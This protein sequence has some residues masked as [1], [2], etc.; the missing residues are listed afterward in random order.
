MAY[1]PFNIGTRLTIL[2][3]AIGFMALEYGLGRLAD[4]DSHDWRESVASFGVGIGQ[5]LGKAVEAALIAVP[6]ALVPR[7]RLFD[8]DQT[9][10]LALVAVFVGREFST[11]GITAPR[12][13][14][15]GCG[16]P[17]RCIIRQRG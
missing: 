17:M 1:A 3:V 8:F 14:S 4:H 5:T 6:F 2:L 16:R 13:G 11:T 9:S 15:A 7:H 12:T 10:P